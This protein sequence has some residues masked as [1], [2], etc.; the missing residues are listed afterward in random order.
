[1]GLAEF[2]LRSLA[3]SGVMRP[4]RSP[5]LAFSLQDG[6]R[7]GL[8]GEQEAP[9]ALR[10]APVSTHRKTYLSFQGVNRYLLKAS[11]RKF[12]GSSR[13]QVSTEARYVSGLGA[14]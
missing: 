6:V 7:E 3:S 4:T 8:P 14:P 1:M 10:K 2:L 5:E 13:T 9:S 12:L 11:K